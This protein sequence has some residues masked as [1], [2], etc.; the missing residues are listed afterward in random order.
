MDELDKLKD[1][2]PLV[3]INDYS[4]IIL[5][6]T[7]IIFFSI[8]I[9]GFYYLKKYLKIKRERN[10]RDFYY[11]KLK[12]MDMQNSKQCAYTITKYGKFLVKE[13]KQIE[14]LK[15]LNQNLEI[16]KYTNIPPTLSEKDKE[17]IEEFMRIVNV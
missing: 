6:L 7:I 16:Y 17:M 12:R 3:E 13:D 14:L 9:L 2:K 8:S 10:K 4:F 15:N 11:Q 1:I 5:I